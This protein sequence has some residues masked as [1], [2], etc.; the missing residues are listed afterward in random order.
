[1][2]SWLAP[3]RGVF[4][5]DALTLVRKNSESSRM[6][7]LLLSSRSKS[8]SAGR[9]PLADCDR[10]SSRETEPDLFPRWRETLGEGERPPWL[11][12]ALGPL[13]AAGPQDT[14]FLREAS[15]MLFARV[16]DTIDT[17]RS[18]SI[19]LLEAVLLGAGR[20]EADRTVDCMLGGS[21][22]LTMAG[23]R[24]ISCLSIAGALSDRVPL[25]GI[26]F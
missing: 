11:V 19:E 8:G 15:F 10:E 6:L 23:Y 7:S 16:D 18:T 4:S 21:S 22:P 5:I 3:V 24:I 25:D 2:A 12:C 26:E 17:S 9:R 20:A 1:M 13:T 14:R